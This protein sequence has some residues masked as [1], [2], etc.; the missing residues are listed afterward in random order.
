MDGLMDRQMEGNMEGWHL[1][2]DNWKPKGEETRGPNSS[3][4]SHSPPGRGG[5]WMW[6]PCLLENPLAGIPGEAE[7]SVLTISRDKEIR[8]WCDETPCEA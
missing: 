2:K 4:P 7:R 8:M 3:T 6:S 5:S 1:S